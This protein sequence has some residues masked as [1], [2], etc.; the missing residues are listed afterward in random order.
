MPICSLMGN[1]QKLS[2]GMRSGGITAYGRLEDVEFFASGHEKP[3]KGP[4]NIDI[5]SEDWKTH[6]SDLANSVAAGRMDQATADRLAK[7]RSAA[8]INTFNDDE[9]F[10]YGLSVMLPR[11]KFEFFYRIAERHIGA[12]LMYLFSFDYPLFGSKGAPSSADFYAGKGTLDAMD[13]EI[14]V[15][16]RPGPV[17]REDLKARKRF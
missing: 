9:G 15:T 13:V 8:W 4:G 10:G 1:M 17:A 14:D 3:K 16:M 7:M 6:E 5:F 2:M 12:D 11:P